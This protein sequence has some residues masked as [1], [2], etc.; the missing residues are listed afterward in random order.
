MPPDW[1]G[2]TVEAQEADPASTLHLYRT[3]IQLRRKLAELQGHDF[4]WL[5]APDGCLAYRRGGLAVWLNAGARPVPMP[6]GEL[7]HASGPVGAEL[8]PDTAVWLRS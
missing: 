6:A 4:E 7:V 5:A 3:T 2:V 1:A 8:A